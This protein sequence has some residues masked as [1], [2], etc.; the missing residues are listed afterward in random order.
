MLRKC[1]DLREFAMLVVR[2]RMDV[3]NVLDGAAHN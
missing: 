3:R 1:H 2:I